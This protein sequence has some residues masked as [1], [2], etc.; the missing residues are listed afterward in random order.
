MQLFIIFTQSLCIEWP[1]L[2]SAKMLDAFAIA[3]L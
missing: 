2:P 1:H 3:D